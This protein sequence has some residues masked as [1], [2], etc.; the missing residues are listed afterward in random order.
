MIDFSIGGMKEVQQGLKQ[1]TGPEMKRAINASL[2]KTFGPALKRAK[3]RT[4]VRTGN[5]R[6]SLGFQATRD[7]DSLGV[8]IISRLRFSTKDKQGKSARFEAGMKRWSTN[9]VAGKRSVRGRHPRSYIGRIEDR[10]HMLERAMSGTRSD[11][12]RIFKEDIRKQI[13]KQL[14]KR[15]AKRGN[16]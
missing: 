11:V 9:I 4:P 15:K 10:E 2:R 13:D 16:G 1:L 8:A 12:E 3:A 14:A 6:A 7:G 5:L